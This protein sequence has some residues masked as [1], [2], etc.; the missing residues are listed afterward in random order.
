VA[1]AEKTEIVI[2]D[3]TFELVQ[4]VPDS[5]M[6]QPLHSS[7]Y[8]EHLKILS[9]ET[10]LEDIKEPEELH[11]QGSKEQIDPFVSKEALNTTSEEPKVPKSEDLS[12]NDDTD[13]KKNVSGSYVN[14][15]SGFLPSQKIDQSAV[16]TTEYGTVHVIALDKLE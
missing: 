16:G 3:D 13:S 1:H 12:L 8:T 7:A 9:A 14:N 4:E 6:S 5:T 2:P 10:G 15:G 11:V